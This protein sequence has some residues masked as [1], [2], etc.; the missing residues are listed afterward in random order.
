MPRSLG[1]ALQRAAAGTDGETVTGG[2]RVGTTSRGSEARAVP[3][4]GSVHAA[5]IVEETTGGPDETTPRTDRT[6]HEPITAITGPRGVTGP[7]ARGARTAARGRTRGTAPIGAYGRTDATAMTAA[8][9]VSGHGVR[10][11]PRRAAP[12]V[13]ADGQIGIARAAIVRR[14]TAGIRGRLSAPSA[15]ARSD[16][17]ETRIAAHVPGAPSVG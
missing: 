8:I 1:R 4:M 13:N 15:G 11:P 17:A 14:L 10:D 9:G 7:T 12:I 3:A 6:P 5:M 2:A 16:E